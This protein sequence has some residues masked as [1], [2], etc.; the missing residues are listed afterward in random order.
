MKL[1]RFVAK[2]MRQALAKIK[3]ELGAEAVI[4]SNK[5]IEGG[6]EIIAGVEETITP[7]ST[8]IEPS[9]P[10]TI[11]SKAAKDNGPLSRMLKEDEVTLGQA[12]AKLKASQTSVGG[13]KAQGFAK[14]LLEILERQQQVQS[15]QASTNTT[16]KSAPNKK[17][18]PAPLSEQTGLKDLFLNEEEKKQALK[19]ENSHG[20]SSYESKESAKD[21]SELSKMR[22]EVDSIRKLLQFELAGLMAD[23]KKREEPVKAMV[24]ELLLG[25]GFDKKV[26]LALSDKIDS[27][28]SFNFAWRQ[29]ASIVEDKLQVGNDEIVSQGGIVTLIGPAGVGKTTTLAKLAAR[30]VMKFGPDR[31]ALVTADHY[32]IGAVEQVKTYGRIMGCSTFAIKS[33]DEL[34]QMLYTLKDKSLVLVDTVGVGLKDERFGTQLAQL[35]QQA[36]LKLKHYLVLPATAQRRVLEQAYEHFSSLGVQGLILTKV[37]ESESIADALS[38]CLSKELT[39]SY[40]TDGQRVPEDLQIPN[41]RN[42]ALKALSAVENDVAKVALD[43]NVL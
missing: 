14:S 5:R 24:Y 36:K 42:L 43:E 1:K 16:P 10:N 27:D 17:A 22:Q 26:A 19:V 39:L 21:K 9:T 29:L 37:D 15:K 32:R 33:L 28:A 35:K 40:V 30:F 11:T 6:V 2:D 34:P 8:P 13:Q 3:E 18:P 20:I 4:M 38:L 41:A 12:N 23:S 31:V 7:H 25:S